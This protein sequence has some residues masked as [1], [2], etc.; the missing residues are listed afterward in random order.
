MYRLIPM[1]CRLNHHHVFKKQQ[2][3]RQSTV[4]VTN[5]T[6]DTAQNVKKIVRPKKI[7]RSPTDLLYTLSATVG[8]DPTAKHYKF[9][10]DPFL[11]P[12]RHSSRELY[13]LAQESG[14]RTAQ[15]IRDKY[16]HL[17]NVSLVCV[18]NAYNNSNSLLKLFIYRVTRPSHRSQHSCQNLILPKKRRFHCVIWKMQSIR[19]MQ[20]MQK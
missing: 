6:T 10:D 8:R 2:I 4:A 12:P 17:F 20:P 5:Q 15:W 13:A 3:V 16:G 1:K 18:C 19:L 11:T 7:D 9:H 14:K